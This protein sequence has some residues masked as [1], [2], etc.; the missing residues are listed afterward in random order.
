MY[1]WILDT[2]VLMPIS[3]NIKSKIIPLQLYL[4]IDEDEKNF[5]TFLDDIYVLMMNYQADTK[6]ANNKKFKVKDLLFGNPESD[7]P[8]NFYN[9]IKRQKQTFN[10]LQ[11]I[12]NMYEQ[13]HEKY[14]DVYEGLGIYDIFL[15]WKF[16]KPVEQSQRYSN[17]MTNLIEEQSQCYICYENPPKKFAMCG[18]G[19]CNDCQDFLVKQKD[20]LLFCPC[21]LCRME[22]SKYDWITID[23]NVVENIEESYPSKY[24]KM[25][26]ELKN[27]KK[28]RILIIV[29][30]DTSFQFLNFLK[31]RF[32]YHQIIGEQKKVIDNFDLIEGDEWICIK[33]EEDL[34]HCRQQ[35]DMEIVYYIS[36]ELKHLKYT[37][38][39]LLYNTISKPLLL[40]MLVISNQIQEQNSLIKLLEIF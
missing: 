38:M 25:F 13:T 17:V 15:N 8:F 20:C 40:V 1:S 10:P 2:C 39:F 3:Q 4:S 36:P 28:N 24:I 5:I 32:Y 11:G 27:S 33:E 6:T 29:P 22:I 35:I 12:L 16:D 30:Q 23:N 14:R 21:P 37:Y 18:H 26:E 7:F 34:V 9:A 31:K 19:Y